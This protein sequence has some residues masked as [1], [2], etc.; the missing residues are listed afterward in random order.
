[1][2]PPGPTAGPCPLPLLQCHIV[3]HNGRRPGGSLAHPLPIPPPPDPEPTRSHGHWLRSV[4]I[5]SSCSF[6]HFSPTIINFYV[7]IF[8]IAPLFFVTH[9]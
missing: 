8:F 4:G 9:S 6:P 2:S 1:M 5:P 3:T 7:S